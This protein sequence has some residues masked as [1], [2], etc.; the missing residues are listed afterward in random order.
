MHKCRRGG[1][2]TRIGHPDGT[3]VNLQ[4]GATRATAAREHADAVR[5][6][7][8]AIDTIVHAA[9]GGGITINARAARAAAGAIHRVT[10]AGFSPGRRLVTKRWKGSAAGS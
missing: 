6:I 5:R 8:L 7:A 2:D 3:V 9:G 1:I 4:R 10:L